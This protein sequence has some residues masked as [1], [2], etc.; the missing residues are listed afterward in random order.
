MLEYASGK[1]WPLF[2]M[3]LPGGSM[4]PAE[5]RKL[6][7]VL[8]ADLAGS[9]E[10]AVTREPEQFRA[11]L[12]AFFDEMA[13]Q[14]RVFGG[15]VEKYAGDAVM[16]VFG[17]PQVHED[18]AERAVRAAVAMRESVGQLNSMFEQEYGIRLD[19]RIGVASGEAVAV[20]DSTREFMV[21]GEVAN[22][23]ARLQSAATGIVVSDATYRFVRSL[24]ES[25]SRA[26]RW[27]KRF[28]APLSAHLITRLRAVPASRG[29]TGLSSPVVGRDRELEALRRCG[30]EL[31]HGRGQIVSILGE[32]GIGKSRLKNELREHRPERV[33]WLEGR[34]QAF[35]QTT[36]Y[37]PIIQ[38]LRAVFQ[39]GG[40]ETPQ[41]AK[42]KLR[43][44]LRALT[45]GN[46]D[47][48]HVAVGH[49]LGVDAEPGTAIS[50]VTD[51]RA[52]QSQLAL[53]LRSIVEALS[54]RGPAALVVEDLH[55]ADPSTVEILSVL[56]ELTDVLPLMI[57]VTSRPDQDGSSWNFRFHAQRHYPHRLTELNLPPLVHE[58]SQRLVENLLQLAELPEAMRGRIIDQSEGNPFFVEELIRTLIE[59][60]ALRRDGERWVATGSVSR[61]A[62]PPT[63]RGLIAGRI[64]RL[65]A[66]AK[67]VLQRASVVGRFVSY[68]A[69]QSL[70]EGHADLDRSIAQLLRA[71]LLREWS[72]L[73]ERQYI[74]K[75][76]LTQEAAAS[77]IL[78]DERRAL[79]R[80][81]ALFFEQE[82]I[83]AA[84]RA[85]L[86]AHHWRLAEDW[87]RAL[88]HS[89]E[90]A[91]RA[92][93]LYARPEAIAHY[94]QALDLVA[95]LPT[96]P[97]RE[98][99][100]IDTVLALARE[101]GW[102][103][104]PAEH[105]AGL[106]HLERA[107]ATAARLEDEPRL[108]KVETILGW[109]SQDEDA[110]L[111]ALDRAKLT[112]DELLQTIA[113]LFYGGYL[114][115][116]GRYESSLVHIGRAIEVL[117][118]RGETSEQAYEMASG[119]RCYSAR[120]G[121]L[122][123]AL[124]YAARA[125]ELGDRLDDPRLRA[126]R[127]AE[128][129]PYM[130]KGLWEDALRVAEEN[131]PL[132]WE[133]REWGPAFWVSGWAAIAALKLGR[134]DVARRLLDRALPEC[135]ALG[136]SQVWGMVW[137][138]MGL[139]QLSLALDQKPEALAAARRAAELAE[140][141]HFRLEQGAAFRV[142]GQTYDASRD[143]SAANAAFRRSLDVLEA[144]QSRP[145][146][147]QTLLA[148][149]CF[150]ARSDRTAGRTLVKRALELFEAMAA[151]GWVAEARQALATSA[152]S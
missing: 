145:E 131:L 68:R 94:W 59:E 84:G 1:I 58:D 96:T 110:L 120:A 2:D 142:L 32:A 147:G 101:P 38:I 19:L 112:S 80:R 121:Q 109:H 89:R 53:A 67:A 34:C 127:A 9:T 130:Y 108:V 146:L 71:E 70:T 72:H 23:A 100:H 49:L 51:P 55:W 114:G 25:E 64:D 93:T 102:R 113:D 62:I 65:S 126:W 48:V 10:L 122:A 40:T 3:T 140:K 78:L 115:Q 95:R 31:A 50:M 116:V 136:A 103:R 27:L 92:R 46:Y 132:C 119:G 139:A 29:V 42:A 60:G 74:F 54:T 33:R 81:L 143:A 83:P 16:A 14:I 144:I 141:S 85:A 128:A 125:R 66:A 43:V 77:S 98:R 17:V 106:Q 36:S 73:P 79:H 133:I 69:L 4:A 15:T 45:G 86:L 105:A 21:T 18:D 82:P 30:E 61:I 152:L 52:L 87:D 124:D 134:H 88:T 148:Y 7:T 22:L 57:L 56:S 13:A 150:M 107:L 12:S 117:G 63:L 44:G 149:G 118:T 99:I 137:L 97:D 123:E 8:F 37:G 90:A 20:T 24:V 41:V 39:L 151:T 35:T 135:E 5:E 11:L 6:V 138:Q 28:S 104:N 129:E 26:A 76:A 47:R 111:R 75:H 91:E